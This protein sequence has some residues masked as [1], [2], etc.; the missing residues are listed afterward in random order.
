MASLNIDYSMS[1][2]DA[3]RTS[4]TPNVTTSQ[5]FG[6]TNCNFNQIQMLVEAF[7]YIRL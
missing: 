2:E 6:A 5:L 4:R 3:D 1:K 7:I